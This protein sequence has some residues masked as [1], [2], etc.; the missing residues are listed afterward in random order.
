MYPYVLFWDIDLYSIFLLLGVIAAFVIFRILGDRKGFAAKY[1]NFVLLDGFLSVV[2]GY[3]GAVLSQAVYN[4]AETGRFVLDKNT[5]ATFLGGL[6]FGAGFFLTFYFS[7]GIAAFRK[8]DNAHLR[9]FPELMSIAGASIP[10]AHA[11]GRI[12]CL[13]AGC[14][15][16]KPT[17]SF[18]GIH[19]VDLPHKTIPVQ[20]FESVFLF[21]LFAVILIL[22]VRLVKFRL[23]LPVYM[24]AYGI[25]RYFAEF[26]RGD[27]RGGFFI[28]IFTPSQ[29]TSVLLVAGGIL[30]GVILYKRYYARSRS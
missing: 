5:G 25:W 1:Q 3:L 26:M 6:L 24:V 13:F 8:D 12:G 18:I 7:V 21:A 22:N 10:A 23:G 29:F 20:I 2:V 27:D 9:Y 17:D 15:Y 19:L 11:L 30:L 4:F 28:R 14:C 16:G